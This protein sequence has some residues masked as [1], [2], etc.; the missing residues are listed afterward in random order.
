VSER[1]R[2]SRQLT[3]GS[4]DGG[5]R[6]RCSTLHT[7]AVSGGVPAGSQVVVAALSGPGAAS[8]ALVRLDSV[9]VAT[10]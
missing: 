9:G 5:S 1:P 7:L 2:S 3:A 6:S 4:P 8:L 10:T